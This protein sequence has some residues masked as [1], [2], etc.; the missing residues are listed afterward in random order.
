MVIFLASYST[1]WVRKPSPTCFDGLQ[2]QNET[3][4][5]CGGV[6][7]KICKDQAL[8]LITRWAQVFPVRSGFADAAAYIVNPN[9]SF[10]LTTVRYRFKIYDA[11]E[12]LVAERDGVTFVNAAEQFII[13]E[14][15]IAVRERVIRR[16]FIELT[17]QENLVWHRSGAGRLAQ[18]TLQDKTVSLD[19]VPTLSA[20][21]HNNS[22]FDAKDVSAVGVLY[23]D[24][25]NAMGVSATKLD[26]VAR[27]ADTPVLWTW[28]NPFLS[29][30]ASS[31]IYL[32]TPRLSQ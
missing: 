13:Y 27:L 17:P 16:A 31:E 15:L 6:C 14:P 9:P 25:G 20:A 22:A 26:T 7:Q 18:F 11:D 28:P 32:H 3:G 21:V 19:P 10:E 4:I 12:Q 2:N 8:P 24:H 5:D 29:P 1:Y 30:I 23:D